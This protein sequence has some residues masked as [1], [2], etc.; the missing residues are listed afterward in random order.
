MP[1]ARHKAMEW[2]GSDDGTG[3]AVPMLVQPIVRF[4]SALCFVVAWLSSPRAWAAEPAESESPEAADSSWETAETPPPPPPP[5]SSGSV[6]ASPY[7]SPK[8]I[9]VTQ[10]EPPPPSEPARKDRPETLFGGGDYA[11]GGFGGM[12]VMYTRFANN[13]V[14]QVCGEGAVIIDHALTFGGGGCGIAMLVHAA[15]FGPPPHDPRDRLSFGYGGAIV[16]YHFYSRRVANLGVGALVGAGG[17]AIGPLTGSADNRD[18]K[19]RRTEA[20]FVFEP[21]IGG[22]LNITR[23]LRVGATAGYRIVSPVSTAGLSA[24]DVGGL[25]VGGRVELGWF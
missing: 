12:G 15:N 6:P 2:P 18:Y 24:S 23:W 25:S 8:P 7:E 5:R 17:L 14:V 3:L 20:L 9:R 1:R 16:R 22:Y 21:Q 10:P 4:A 19:P 11:I 13:D